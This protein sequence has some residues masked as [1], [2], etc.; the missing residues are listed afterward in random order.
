VRTAWRVYCL[1]MTAN[2][3]AGVWLN[4]HHIDPTLHTKTP[5][6]STITAV[7][8][9]P[10]TAASTGAH[11]VPLHTYR[12]ARVEKIPAPDGGEGSDW[13]GYVLESGRSIITGQR[14]GSR[15][16]VLTYATECAERLNAR[17]RN[18]EPSW[19][20]RGKKTS[21]LSCNSTP[22]GNG[23]CLRSSAVR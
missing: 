14:R 11:P 13:R 20:P 6:S 23:S 8:D 2:P 10:I 19:R 1:Q 12:V 3:F 9:A 7:T 18:G 21:T 17:G 22:L 16:A 5:M 4:H 15:E